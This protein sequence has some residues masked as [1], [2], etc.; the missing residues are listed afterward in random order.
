[1]VIKMIADWPGIF[2]AF[3]AGLLGSAHCFGMC[4]GIVGALQLAIPKHKSAKF[5]YL[6]NYNLGRIIG[7]SLLGFIASIVSLSVAKTLGV[8]TGLNALR[9]VGGLFLFLMAAYIGRWWMILSHFEKMGQNLFN[10]IRAMGK[11]WL[12]LSNPFQAIL[13]GIFWGFLPCGLVYSAL[14]FSATAPTASDSVLRMTAFG[15]GT[16]PALGL[17]GSFASAI[18]TYLQRPSVK[19]IAAMLLLIVALWTIFP[20]LM[21]I[22]SSSAHHH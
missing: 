2:A 8:N 18:K 19:Q 15:F 13:V 20:V 5:I 10:P 12:P 3:L 17:M 22:F 1:M 14:A 6:L 16:L 7:Y 4:G 9:L 21:Q 11:K